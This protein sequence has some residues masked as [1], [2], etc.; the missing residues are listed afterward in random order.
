[1]ARTSR[2]EPAHPDAERREET[3]ERVQDEQAAIR[4][5]RSRVDA[6][7]S[8]RRG[9]TPI[10][11]LVHLGAGLAGFVLAALVIGVAGGSLTAVLT[12]GL[13]AGIAASA[14]VP[15]LPLAREDGR[16]A[17][18]VATYAG[19]QTPPEQNATRR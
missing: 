8:T 9:V 18:E 11:V 19:P 2:D 14:L 6:D 1:M 10:T 4:G 3:L 15:L 5:R 17:D 13:L 12:G 7:P 16:V